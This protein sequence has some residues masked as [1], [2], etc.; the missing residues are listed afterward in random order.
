MEIDYIDI[1]NILFDLKWKIFK[2]FFDKNQ[3][4]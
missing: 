4:C 3:L 2:V 1:V